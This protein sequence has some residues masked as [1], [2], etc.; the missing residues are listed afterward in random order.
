MGFGLRY[1]VTSFLAPAYLSGVLYDRGP[2]DLPT[3]EDR[4]AHS[5]AT[6]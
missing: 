6:S 2:R 1:D 5:G 3:S 4:T